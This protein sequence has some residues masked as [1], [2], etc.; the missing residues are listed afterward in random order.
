[1][2]NKVA[3][4]RLATGVPGLSATLG[5]G[6]PEYPFNLITGSAGSGK[7]TPAQQIVFAFL[8]SDRTGT[9]NCVSATTGWRS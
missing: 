9:P 6:L 2:N 1:M 5:R 3:I 7:T 8:D 4:R